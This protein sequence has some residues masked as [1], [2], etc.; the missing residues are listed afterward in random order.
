MLRAASCRLGMLGKIIVT[1]GYTDCV[2]P[3][4]TTYVYLYL[5]VP[6]LP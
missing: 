5:H 6:F 4:K 1:W 2:P 3:A